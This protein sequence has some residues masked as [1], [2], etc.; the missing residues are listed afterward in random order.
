MI[1]NYHIYEAIWTAAIGEL[2]ECQREIHNHRDR[3]RYTEAHIHSLHLHKT[4]SDLMFVLHV[5]VGTPYSDAYPQCQL[6]EIRGQDLAPSGI[7][8][9]GRERRCVFNSAQL[10]SVSIVILGCLYLLVKVYV[11]TCTCKCMYMY[12]YGRLVCTH[13]TTCTYNSSSYIL[14]LSGCS[15][16]FQLLI[17]SVTLSLPCFIMT[18][19]Y[20]AVARNF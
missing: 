8:L 16:T 17:A 15:F 20:G 7:L 19:L 12:V 10:S 6:G 18:L 9:L 3:I 11:R 4:R 2:L 1:H 13:N 5:T 14:L